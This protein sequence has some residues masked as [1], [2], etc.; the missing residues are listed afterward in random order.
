M[1]QT[2]A[3]KPLP[4]NLLAQQLL[5][6]GW[7]ARAAEGDIMFKTAL[8][9]RFLRPA[10]D[11]YIREVGRPQLEWTAEVCRKALPMTGSTDSMCELVHDIAAWRQVASNLLK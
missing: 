1:L 7:A 11:K 10:A 5:L 9:D 6:F 3:V 4:Q 8:A 2:V